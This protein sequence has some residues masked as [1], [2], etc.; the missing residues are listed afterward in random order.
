MTDLL[1]LLDEEQEN[2]EQPGESLSPPATANARGRGDRYLRGHQ[3]TLTCDPA[4]A[5]LR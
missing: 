4:A 1:L 2:P 5:A 3:I